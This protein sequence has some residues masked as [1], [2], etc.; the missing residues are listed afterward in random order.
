MNM[1]VLSVLIL[2]F[3]SIY[4]TAQ[5]FDKMPI[6]KRDSILIEL[7]RKDVKKYAP[8]YYREFETP[9]IE[10][11]VIPY[12]PVDDYATDIDFGTKVGRVFY[13]VTFPYDTN[14]EYFQNGMSSAVDRWADGGRLKSVMPGNGPGRRFKEFMT[15]S[16]RETVQ[17]LPYVVRKRPE[18]H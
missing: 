6:L 16:E 5:D 3:L 14:K 2:S 4:A 1:K 15:H 8:G 12:N 9:V 10:R 11:F 17:I 18:R 7:A 13:R